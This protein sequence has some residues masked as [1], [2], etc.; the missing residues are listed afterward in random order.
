MP[1]PNL[2]IGGAPKC[3]TSSL[4]KWLADHPEVCGS[5][6]KETFYLMDK[7]NPLLNKKSN[8]HENG[9]LGYEAKFNN[10]HKRS[11]I[12]FES[13]THYMY[14]N[15]ARYVLSTL[16]TFPKVIFVLRKPS[17]RIYSSYQ[18]TRNNIANF[19]KDMSFTEFVYMIK[20][21]AT[22][23]LSRNSF[24]PASAFVLK[25]D[26]EYSQY[27][28][29]IRP[30]VASLGRE[31]VH[32]FL[33]EEMRQSPHDFMDRLSRCIGI[34]AAFYTKYDFTSRNETYQIT[35]KGLHRKARRFA[36][37]FPREGVGRALRNIYFHLQD[38]CRKKVVKS[39]ED[40]EVLAM[41]ERE[42]EPFNKCLVEEISLDLSL[43]N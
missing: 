17:E 2:I 13:T 24:S 19:K 36:R 21:G 4:F 31:R 10:C 7:D 9:L 42:F 20:S 6:V 40:C 41:L 30:W 23:R 16:M 29:Y 3:G 27:I 32:V 37:Y 8:F 5:S 43:W 25:H 38:D 34:D 14:Q 11:K 39:R 1:L 12:I 18:Y 33:F 15:T 22:E 26:I 35:Y 28:N